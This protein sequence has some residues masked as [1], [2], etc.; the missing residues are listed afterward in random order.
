MAITKDTI[1]SEI[2]ADYQKALELSKQLAIQENRRLDQMYLCNELSEEEYDIKRRNLAAQLQ[3]LELENRRQKFIRQ[4]NADKEVE[5]R[6]AEEDR[7]KAEE[8][9]RRLE[10][11]RKA[12]E[13]FERQRRSDEARHRIESLDWES[14]SAEERNKLLEEEMSKNSAI[15]NLLR[16]QQIEEEVKRKLKLQ[17]LQAEKELLEAEKESAE[18]AEDRARIQQE[19]D[20]KQ[21][22]IDDSEDEV[23]EGE[24]AGKK[25]AEWIADELSKFVSG[26][27]DAVDQNISLYSQYMGKV[28]ARLQTLDT[29]AK[30]LDSIHDKYDKAF[31]MSPY[32]QQAELYKAVDKLSSEGISYNIEER[33]F[34]SSIADKMVASFNVSNQTLT[35]LIRLY[36][37]D[38]TQALLGNEAMLTQI[39]N[40]R[41]EDS[42]YL[43]QNYDE[44]VLSAIST[45]MALMDVDSA[46]EYQYQIQKWLGS[47]YEVGVSGETVM[48]IASAI[49]AL[50]SGNANA[51][52]DSNIGV[53]LNMALR[54]SGYSVADALTQGVTP[55]LIN[56]LMASVI[57]LLHDIKDN[58]SN[59]VTLAAYADT[60]GISV[61]DIR[62]FYNLYDD[63]VSLKGYTTNL[64]EAEAEVEV[65]I[66][67]IIKERTTFA[68]KFNNVMDNLGVSLGF[69]IADSTG[70]YV[71]WKLGGI[72]TDLGQTVGG[73]TGNVLSKIG[74]GDRIAIL[75]EAFGDAMDTGD[76]H[77]Y[78][79]LPDFIENLVNL[80]NPKTWQNVMNN[81][82]GDTMLSFI[83]N[84]E[85]VRVVGDRGLDWVSPAVV[86]TEGT[87]IGT[88]YS[89]LATKANNFGAYTAEQLNDI[90]TTSGVSKSV[91][92]QAPATSNDRIDLTTPRETYDMTAYKSNEI[93]YNNALADSVTTYA[94]ATTGLNSLATYDEATT[95]YSVTGAER[96]AQFTDDDVYQELFFKHDHPI[97]V[98][99][100]DFQL[101]AL[102]QLEIEDGHSFRDRLLNAFL[103]V[104]SGNAVNV[105]LINNDVQTLLSAI[106]SA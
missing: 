6:K 55:D 106:R 54:D 95:S 65:Q 100:K 61:A 87:N 90:I 75:L 60:L 51:F 19:I 105:D 83:E 7:R 94:Q 28:D 10:A 58:T 9:R 2:E 16:R 98:S 14:M 59:Q 97:W 82:K 26:I 45:S 91:S 52:T 25:I 88:A 70:E 96:N 15:Y 40:T 67:D 64:V 102:K 92:L 13:S 56:D 89:A 77:W 11:D 104:L 63:I 32:V 79:F 38:I 93:K 47:L 24:R 30:T 33:A 44:Q 17:Q 43:A 76:K 3:E 81:L 21:Q 68:E 99:V 8:D 48:S 57:T 85:S 4:I 23:S 31:G 27:F 20:N 35:N 62:G 71:A 49:N 5:R 42:S 12:Q 50:G 101:D 53:L 69:N 41:Y 84:S 39:F 73:V 22:E 80:F 74:Y 86:N 46:I 34:L 103:N 1:F 72:L 66:V 18:T 37:Q 29:T 78:S 36:Q